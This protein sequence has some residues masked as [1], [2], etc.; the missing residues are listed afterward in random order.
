M[1][2]LIAVRTSGTHCNFC[3]LTSCAAANVVVAAMARQ[4][5]MINFAIVDRLMV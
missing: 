1:Q 5:A 2:A 4:T 3:R